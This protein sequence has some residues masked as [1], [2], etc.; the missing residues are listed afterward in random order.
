MADRLKH[1]E[2]ELGLAA[3]PSPFAI[4]PKT[5]CRRVETTLSAEET[6]RKQYMKHKIRLAAVLLWP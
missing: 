5:I 2:R 1:L 6:E 3:A 4:D